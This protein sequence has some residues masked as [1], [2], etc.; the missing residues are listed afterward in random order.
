MA[1]D[2]D[3]GLGTL[4][5][6]GLED[7]LDPILEASMA[8]AA[9]RQALIAGDVQAVER[10]L[11]LHAH[12]AGPRGVLSRLAGKGGVGE[13]VKRL[14]PFFQQ[15][16][17]SLERARV[18]G[19]DEVEIYEKMGHPTLPR[20]IRTVSLVRRRGGYWRVVTTSDAPDERLRACI[21]CGPGSVD[22]LELELERCQRAF[23]GVDQPPAHL[24]RD[25]GGFRLD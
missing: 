5:G 19:R 25:A 16:R 13:A 2:S 18:L 3:D 1:S 23:R 7:S 12:G 6:T 15:A 4:L 24:A 8:V 22:P 14:L 11:D 9:H 20:P 10:S 17:F 21:F